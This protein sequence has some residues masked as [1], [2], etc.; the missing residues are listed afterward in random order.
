[1]IN[2]DWL[3]GYIQALKTIEDGIKTHREND[4]SAENYIAYDKILRYINHIRDNYK[5]LVK[6]L[7]NKENK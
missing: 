4:I 3:K 5:D 2:N 7:N 1:M 6:D